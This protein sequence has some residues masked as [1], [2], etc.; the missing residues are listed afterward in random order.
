[1]A[2]IHN[3]ANFIRSSSQ[4]CEFFERISRENDEAQGYLL[5]SEFTAE[6]EVVM[7]NDTRWNSTYLMISRAFL[8]QGDIGA[9][10]VHPEVAKWLLEADMLKRNDWRLLAETKH[11]I[12][13][14]YLQ[15][16]A[17][18]G[19]AAKEVMGMD[20]FGRRRQARNTCWNILRI[21]SCSTMLFQTRQP[22][23]IPTRRS[24]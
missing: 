24:S 2:K 21:G 16:M 19:W 7:N 11:I 4:R 14:F 13:P 23:R 20:G 12:E 17:T 18:Q 5:A 6:L 15:T 3:V 22:K 10:L 8:K 1:M 9:S